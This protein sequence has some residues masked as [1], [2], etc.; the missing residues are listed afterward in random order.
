[1]RQDSQ[2]NAEACKLLVAH[3]GTIRRCSPLLPNRAAEKML[4]MSMLDHE[5]SL[6]ATR[7]GLGPQCH[8]VVSV[9]NMHLYREA[10]IRFCCMLGAALCTAILAEKVQP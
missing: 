3:H 1:M 5:A 10:P 2:P 4:H 9:M 6:H 7:P 8:S